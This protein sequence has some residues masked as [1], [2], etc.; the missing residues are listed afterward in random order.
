MGLVIGARLYCRGPEL[1]AS[2]GRRSGQM[3]DRI[4]LCGLRVYAY[5]GVFDE[6]RANGQPF[7]VDVTIGFDAEPAGRT[8]DLAETVDYGALAGRIV[9]AVQSDP[10]NLIETVAQRVADICL[11]DPVAR[12]VEVTVHK[13]QAPVGVEL[14]DVAITIHR[15][16]T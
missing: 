7:V 16:R 6:E 12:D 11:T 15:S 8:D 10:V 9:A 3:V 4:S 1:G 5:H 13:P 14:D 2:R